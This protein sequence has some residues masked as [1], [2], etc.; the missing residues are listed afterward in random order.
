MEVLEQQL[1]EDQFSEG[2]GIQS[3]A[4]GGASSGDA[5]TCQRI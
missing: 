3:W 4:G 5:E 2:R 1:A